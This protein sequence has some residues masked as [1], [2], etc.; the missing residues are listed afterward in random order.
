MKEINRVQQHQ[1]LAQ[2]RGLIILNKTPTASE[3]R[4]LQQDI[5]K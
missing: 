2:R 3:V 1:T 4:T 5:N